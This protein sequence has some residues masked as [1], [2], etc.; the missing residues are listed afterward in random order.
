MLHIIFGHGDN[1]VSGTG[2]NFIIVSQVLGRWERAAMKFME[3][4]AYQELSFPPL[5]GAEK[6]LKLRYDFLSW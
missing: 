1:A 6:W 3:N 2:T 4:R 5:F